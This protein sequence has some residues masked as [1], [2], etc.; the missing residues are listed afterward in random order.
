MS[1]LELDGVTKRFGEVTAVDEVS[2]AVEAGEVVALVGPNGAGKT[3]LFN[4]IAGV[5]PPSAGD[6][7]FEGESITGLA[8]HEVARRGVARSYQISS[9]FPEL[10]V[11]ENVR[12]AVQR[13]VTRWFDAWSDVRTDD[14]L[15]RQAGAKLEEVGITHLAGRTA[16]E[17]SHGQKRKLEVGLA[18]ALDPELLLL[19]EPTAGLS[20]DN[21][22]AVRD[23][24]DRLSERYTVVFVE[25]DLDLVEELASTV[26]VLSAGRVVATGPPDEIRERQALRESYM[27]VE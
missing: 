26:V 19:D 21:R 11:F 6:V 16:Q 7:V 1:L 8:P 3:T 18:V 20:V 17:L 2:Y 13:P 25:H 14:E 4:V 12:L 22:E 24:V 9:P 27:G 23:L 10:T 15:R 5:E